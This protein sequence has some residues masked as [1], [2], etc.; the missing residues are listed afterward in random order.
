MLKD[1]GGSGLPF[2]VP[3]LPVEVVFI[4]NSP[5]KTTHFSKN[6]TRNSARIPFFEPKKSRNT[7]I[8][9]RDSVFL[10]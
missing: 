2:F 10:L 1:K 7:L 8:V 4:R 3:Q 9:L 6:P 5:S